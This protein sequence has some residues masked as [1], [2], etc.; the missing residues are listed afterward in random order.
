M[1]LNKQR[2]TGLRDLLLSVRV[3][4][5]MWESLH[6]G[7]SFYLPKDVSF[8]ETGAVLEALMTVT[9]KVIMAG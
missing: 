3:P 7:Q 2:F 6:Y 5:L 8:L 9:V 4:S 1:F